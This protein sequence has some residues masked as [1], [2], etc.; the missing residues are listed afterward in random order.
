MNI[1]RDALVTVHLFGGIDISLIGLALILAGVIGGCL[2]IWRGKKSGKLSIKAV[3]AVGIGC[4]LLGLIAGCGISAV[5]DTTEAVKTSAYI[6]I[7][8]ITMPADRTFLTINIGEGYTIYWYGVII[9]V[10]FMLA[11]IYGMKRA[12]SFGIDRDRMLDAVLVGMIGAI[13]CAR[14]Y[15]V[16]FDGV[17]MTSIWDF[18]AIHEGGIAIYG[19]VIGAL[20]FGGITAKLRKINVLAMFDLASLGFLIGQAVGRWG[21]FINQEVY[22]KE[23]GSSWFGMTGSLI[24]HDYGEA[25][26]HP[27][28]LYESLWCLLVFVLLHK[29]SKKK[30]FDGQI[31]CGYI[32]L[33]GAGRFFL[34]GMR[35]HDF[36][37]RFGIGI[38][39][40]QVVSIIAVVVGVAL[41]FI[42]RRRKAP[43]EAYDNQF[44]EFFDDPEMLDAAYEL[45]ECSWDSDDGEVDAAYEERKA[46]FE[47]IETE[48]DGQ[49]AKV[50][51]KLDEIE[52][53]YEYLLNARRAQAEQ[54]K[55][56]GTDN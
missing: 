28:F 48:T 13:F 24:C 41:Y 12:D 43:V 9:A 51:A 36:I 42:L 26:V 37:L 11:L 39:I 20:L 44:E 22:G 6:T 38:S 33:Y 45:L 25:L 21:N 16:M 2:L 15:Y 14:L 4:V 56:D 27:L 30:A 55:T 5:F 40:S 54:E 53:A 17:S 31:F 19:G 50:K 8:G 18:F 49:R 7:F 23:T 47:D 3:Y 32:V 34:E 46:Y 1:L 35:D 29:L 10:G 52:R